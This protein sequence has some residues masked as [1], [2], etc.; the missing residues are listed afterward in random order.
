MKHF[1][2]IIGLIFIFSILIS[3]GGAKAKKSI[4]ASDAPVR[5][6][7]DYAKNEA[8]DDYIRK[9]LSKKSKGKV[10]GGSEIKDV[11]EGE[12]TSGDRDRK[13]YKAPEKSGLKAGYADDNKQFN[14]FVKFLEK[15]KYTVKPDP[16]NIKSK[17]KIRERIILKIKDKNNRSI[18]NAKVKI[19]GDGD[20]LETGKAYA[21]G[22]FLFYPA[23][24]DD[25]IDKYK[26][27]ITYNQSK[28][29]INFKRQGKRKLTVKMKLSRVVKKR[30]PL[31]ILFVMDT[32]GSMGE[33][34]S[35]LKATIEIMNL[36]LASLK[37]RPKLRFGMV[38]YKDKDEEYETQ[39]IPLTASLGKFKE[40]LDEVEA[41]GG[42]DGPED[43]QGALRDTIKKV[44]WN[45]DGLRLVFMIT[46]ASA[47]LDYGQKYTY[48]KAAIDAKK[49]GIKLFSIGTGGLNTMGEYVLRQLSHYTYAKY[50]FLT[51]GEKTESSGGKPGSVSHHTGENFVSGKLE[52]IVIRFAKEEL[53]HA[54]NKPLEE[55][56]SYFIATKIDDEEREKTLRTLFNRAI[57]QLID[58]SSIRIPEKTPTT[59]VPLI[60]KIKGSKIKRD[61]EYFDE[62]M[63]FSLS[64]NKIFKMVERKDLQSILGEMEFQSSDLVD[65][66]SVVKLGEFTGAKMLLIGNIYPGKKNYEI[67]LKLVRVKTAEILAITKMKIDKRLGL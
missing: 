65:S 29:T 56:T 11:K 2:F 7:S 34:I 31:D 53:G 45:K 18:P 21:D 28:K 3:C 40:A 32:T 64:K 38:L 23:M 4:K 63:I 8:T 50:I 67:F 52:A 61:A 44:K 55:G 6:K 22:S 36:N 57:Q 1:K 51:Y 60:Y 24:Y 30:I 49:M 26:A 46:D 35:R 66:K 10:V 12:R 14:Y 17:L 37:S 42:G 25:D 16:M 47:H 9:N 27:Q 59:T 48:A 41:S 19:Y 62:Q 15:Y 20:L 43:L 5:G 33:E 58:F 13:E 54:S 39:V